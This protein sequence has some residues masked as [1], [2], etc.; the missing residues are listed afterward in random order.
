MVAWAHMTPQK[1]HMFVLSGEHGRQG[2][3][4]P[5]E[6]Q[7]W[8]EKGENQNPG[9]RFVT[10]EKRELARDRDAVL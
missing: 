8:A 5:C 7:G 10:E 3:S 9:W 6:Q 1:R 4:W 2:C